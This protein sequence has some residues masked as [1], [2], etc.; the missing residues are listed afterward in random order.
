MTKQA[1]SKDGN[2]FLCVGN[3]M[4]RYEASQATEVEGR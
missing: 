3:N 2:L 1:E 4:Q